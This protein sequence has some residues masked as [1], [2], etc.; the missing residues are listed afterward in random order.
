M[1]KWEPGA[2]PSTRLPRRLDFSPTCCMCGGWL[3]MF[4]PPSFLM[5][6]DKAGNLRAMPAGAT[7]ADFSGSDGDADVTVVWPNTVTG[8]VEAM[9]DSPHT[10]WRVRALWW[11]PLPLLV[12]LHVNRARDKSCVL[13]PMASGL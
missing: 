7:A 10:E 2:T 11:L 13:L 5:L 12:L 6:R 4:V 8:K 1:C 3:H 9:A